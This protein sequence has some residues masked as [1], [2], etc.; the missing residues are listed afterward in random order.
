[1]AQDL[2]LAEAIGDERTTSTIDTTSRS[3]EEIGMRHAHPRLLL[4]DRM[5]NSLDVYAIVIPRPEFN[6]YIQ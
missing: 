6:S 3:R 5:V 1:M 2:N 4:I